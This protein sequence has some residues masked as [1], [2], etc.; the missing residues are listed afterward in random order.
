MCKIWLLLYII[1]CLWMFS[2]K[3]VGRKD[4]LAEITKQITLISLGQILRQQQI[5]SNMLEIC[6]NICD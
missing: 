6:T 4:I 3:Q 1:K 5:A 2:G